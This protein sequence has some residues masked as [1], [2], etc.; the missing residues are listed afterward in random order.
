M[1][2]FGLAILAANEGKMIL[3]SS[4]DGWRRYAP[5]ALV[6]LAYLVG[7][8]VDIME[9]DAAQY[10]TMSRDMLRDGNL[11]ELFDRG[12]P[13]L[14]KPP[15]VFWASMLSFKLFGV[16]TW[17]YKLPSVLFSLLAIWA[18]GRLGRLLH[19]AKAGEYAALVLASCQAFFLMNND[20]KTDMYALAPMVLSVWLAAESIVGKKG[21]GYVL[22]SGLAMGLGMLGKGP[23]A[24]VAPGLALGFHMVLRRDWLGI[25]HW[26]WLLV[27]PGIFLVTLPFS[28]GLHQQYGWK[29][30]EFF[31]WTQS[32]GRVTGESEWKNDA[33]AFFFV[34]TFAWAFLPWLFLFLAAFWREVKQLWKYRFKLPEG[35]EGLALGGFILVF[36]ALSLSRFKLPHYIFITM[37]FAAVMVGA[38][39]A[40]MEG[41]WKEKSARVMLAIHKV[42][43]FVFLVLGALL[44]FGIF[45]EG[46]WLGKVFYVLLAAVI[47]VD[48]VKSKKEI[49]QLFWSTALVFGLVNLGLNGVV[50][51]QILSYQSTGTAGKYIQQNGLKEPVYAFH[52]SGRALDF[53]CGEVAHSLASIHLLPEI[54][55]KGPILLFTNQQGYDDLKTNNVRTQVL[56][57]LPHNAPNR[58]KIQFLNPA[59]RAENLGQ[60]YLLRIDPEDQGR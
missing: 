1:H 18:T 57:N 42:L 12:R 26:K 33:T 55:D 6:V 48:L 7:M 23:I 28:I 4:L 5:M 41:N 13:Y 40:R 21:I 11:L 60:R 20:V 51:P 38:E 2:R 25:F 56:L 9:I 37:P 10:A 8:L 45:P 24:V 54:L 43:A 36:A 32:F 16:H 46:M 34:H 22:L 17:S 29:G 27:L 15:L 47:A 31:F 39:I 58:L 52:K 30:V 3:A 19:G 14:D 49:Q 53:Y 35:K 59:S 50:Y 44:I